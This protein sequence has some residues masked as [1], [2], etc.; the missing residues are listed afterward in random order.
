[1]CEVLRSHSAEHLGK[2][3]IIAGYWHRSIAW[4]KKRRERRKG[5]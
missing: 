5:G 4:K 1:M 3:I 2:A